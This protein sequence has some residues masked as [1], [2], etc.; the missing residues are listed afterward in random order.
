MEVPTS[1]S[2]APR[3]IVPPMSDFSNPALADGTIL[4]SDVRLEYTGRAFYGF[5]GYGFSRTEYVSGQDHFG[6]WFDEPVQRYHPPHDRRHQLNAML[7]LDV[8]G[9]TAGVRWQYGGGMPFTR[10]LGFDELQDFKRHLPNV[11]NTY[12]TPRVILDRPYSGRLPVYHR[13]DVSLERNFSFPAGRL[14]LKAG[15][16]NAYDQ[17]NL[18]YYD[19]YTQRRIDQMPVAPYISIKLETL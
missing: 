15:A 19:V 12:G 16:V 8:A 18:F 4:G 2:C 1:A 14:N 3:R 7:S 5:I 11:L 10:P 9:F 6:T 17:V 13:L